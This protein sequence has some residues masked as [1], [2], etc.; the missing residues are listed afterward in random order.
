MLNLFLRPLRIF[1]QALLGNESPRATAWGFTLGMMLGLVPK[2]N[3]LAVV[4]ALLIGS[5]RVNMA[6]AL[7]TAGLCSYLGA[8]GDDFAHR[9]GVIAL[10][11]PTARGWHEWLYRQPVGPL[12]GLNNTVTLGQLLI[13]L[14]LAYPVYRCGWWIGDRVQPR[15]NRWLMQYRAIRWL[16]GAE[17]TAQWGWES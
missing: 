2:G 9:L 7:L 1:V 14:Y 11:W 16:R 15:L 4:L 6:A 3:L 5:L 10:A 8:L 13:G 12:T 17:W